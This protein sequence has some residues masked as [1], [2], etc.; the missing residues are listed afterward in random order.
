MPRVFSAASRSSTAAR[1]AGRA[2]S[3][4]VPR[5]GQATSKIRVLRASSLALIREDRVRNI[6]RV[7]D[8]PVPALLDRVAPAHVL[9]LAH[10]RASDHRVPEAL[11]LLVDHRLRVRLRA[12]HDPR[13]H[14]RAVA[15]SS[16]PRLKKA[17]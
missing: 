1:K 12:L 17:R 7:P 14:P 9:D 16:I 3:R 4:H 11:A 8:L 2:A 10:V 15:G 6:L 13:D 5:V